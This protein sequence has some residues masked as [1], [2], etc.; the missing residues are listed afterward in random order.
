M[1]APARVGSRTGVLATVDNQIDTSTGTIK[2]K[3]QFD[4]ADEQLFP[5]QFVNVRLLVD[6]VRGATVVPS[7]A[8]Q[9]GAKGTYVY[10]VGADATASAQ[11]VT[12]GL[13]EGELTQVTR[14]I[15]PG[16]T[17]VTDGVDRLRD[18]IKVSLQAAPTKPGPDR[19]LEPGL[20]ARS[21]AKVSRRAS[22][23]RGPSMNP[24]RI[25]VLRPVAT[26]LVMVAIVL[27]GAGRLSFP[28]A[29]GAAAGRLSDHPGARPSIPA[30]ARR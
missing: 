16:Q 5:N 29:L 17:V 20:G 1:T 3:A 11:P 10:V 9:R 30:P 7:A 4:N 23:C 18:G 28:A 19:R 2:L 24:S 27:A 8:V 15:E 25:F 13:S 12:V 22:A 21:R 6:T 14:G 26:S